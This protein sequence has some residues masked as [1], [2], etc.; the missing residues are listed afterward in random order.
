MIVSHVFHS[1]IRWRGSFSSFSFP[2]LSLWFVRFGRLC[3]VWVCVS[4]LQCRCT[5]WLGVGVVCL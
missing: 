4:L 3:V 5:W 2:S 1:F